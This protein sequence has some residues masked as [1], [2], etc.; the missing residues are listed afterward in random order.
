LLA[1]LEEDTGTDDVRHHEVARRVT[2]LEED[3]GMPPSTTRSSGQTSRGG[4]GRAGGTWS[5]VARSASA[6]VLAL[7]TWLGLPL[8]SCWLW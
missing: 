1:G 7:V 2:T 4:R 8:R 5:I 3:R 6:I